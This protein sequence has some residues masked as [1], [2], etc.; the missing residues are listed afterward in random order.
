[1]R[2]VDRSGWINAFPEKEV[3]FACCCLPRDK[4]SL[5]YKALDTFN[6]H[7]LTLSLLKCWR[8]GTLC[9]DLFANQGVVSV[10]SEAFDKI[11]HGML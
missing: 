8:S 5:R 9:G 4:N 2:W 6:L 1:M 11:S 3:H 7:G 10:P